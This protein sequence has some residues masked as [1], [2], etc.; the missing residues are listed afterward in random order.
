MKPLINDFTLQELTELITEMGEPAYRGKQIWQMIYKQLIFDP[1]DFSNLSKELRQK[2]D[3]RFCFAP[4]RPE[5]IL[6]SSDEQTNKLLFCLQDGRMIESV[7]M[8]Y[9]ERNT[10]CISTQVG[11]P[12]N[13]AFCATGQMGFIRNLSTGEIVGQV[14]YFARLLKEEGKKLTN[15][16]VMGMGEPFHNYDAVMKAIDIINDPDGMNFGE[17]R[18]TIST[19][20][21]VPRIEQFTAAKRQVN[22]AVS[23]HAPSNAV[24]D[25][26][27]PANKKYPIDSLLEACKNYTEKTGRRITFEYALIHGLNDNYENAVQLCKRLKGM[28]CHVNLIPLNSTNKY[29]GSG[30]NHDRTQSFK[31]VLDKNGIPCSVRLKRGVDIGAGCGQLLAEQ[32]KK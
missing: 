5:K 22:L 14:L 1:A 11:C 2:L 4:L 18:I 17:R 28:L 26:I 7:L 13:C 30:S 8:R 32:N 21:L 31:S 10:I 27:I 24:R 3:E 16:V 20:G 19:V 23:L 9:N 29:E 6:K 15:I 25:K 12:M